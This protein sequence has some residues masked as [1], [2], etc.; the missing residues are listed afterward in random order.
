MRTL[1]FCRNRAAATRSKGP[2]R[3]PKARNVPPMPASLGDVLEGAIAARR[4]IETQ[5]AN[6]A[7]GRAQRVAEN[8]VAAAEWWRAMESTLTLQRPRGGRPRDDRRIGARRSDAVRRLQR[9]GCAP[10][11]ILRPG[12]GRKAAPS[13]PPHWPRCAGEQPG[14]AALHTFLARWMRRCESVVTTGRYS[15]HNEM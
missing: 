12:R 4:A 8:S 7:K 6:A 2:P 1:S 10:C 11:A 5:R 9:V 14:T 15:H 3:A 13:W